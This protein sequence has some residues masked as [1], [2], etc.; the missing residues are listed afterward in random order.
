MA[1]IK[2]SNCGKYISTN[3]E[4]CV[5]CGAENER[6]GEAKTVT[7]ERAKTAN[8]LNN[9]RIVAIIL[10]ILQIIGYGIIGSAFSLEFGATTCLFFVGCSITIFFTYF[11]I[12]LMKALST[13]INELNQINSHLSNNSKID[14]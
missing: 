7:I 1:V 13:I 3:A 9:F 6:F 11:L 4:K 5:H 2:C 10:A 14:K 8:T 12:A